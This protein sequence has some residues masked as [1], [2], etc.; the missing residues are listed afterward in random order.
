MAAK[1]VTPVRRGWQ[2]LVPL[3]AATVLLAACGGEEIRTASG[4]GATCDVATEKAWL[5]G[6]MEDRY[7]WSGLAANP[8]PAP[9]AS[10][11]DYFEA[12]RYRP[13]PA[14]TTLYD[15]W[16]YIA[17]KASY[18][19]FFAEGRTLG[20]GLSV[21]GIEL[22]L[23]LKARYVD[24]GS[25]AAQAGLVRGDTIVSLNGRSAAEL[26]AANDFSALSAAAEGQTLEVVVDRGAGAVP[27]TLQATTYDLVPVTQVKVVGLAGGGRAGYLVLKDFIVQAER[28]LADAFDFFAAQGATQ[29][30][31]DLRYNG[32]GRVSTATTLASLIAGVQNN[33]QVFTQLRYNARHSG[34]NVNYLLGGAGRPGF[35]KV[36][37]LTGPRTCSAS[38]LVVNGLAPYVEVVTLG[39]A[40]CGK[41]FGFN[42]VSNCDSVYSAV[43][44]ESVN[45]LGQ[46]GYYQ[47]IAAQC[48]VADDFSRELG[49]PAEKLLAA[50]GD[51]LVSGACAAAPL[52]E[53]QR[54]LS[55]SRRARSQGAEPGERQGMFVD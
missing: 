1:L 4:G 41:P 42:P 25:P 36:V 12:L 15:A 23:P 53:R 18:F 26:V 50:A 48:A 19:Q 5:R 8:D 51:R 14:V 10:V 54:A 3:L 34:D 38:E 32:G 22:Q 6:Y 2:R 40:S 39:G 49:D 20:Y 29:L 9:Y 31:L 46:G 21:N 43:N 44:F 47:G 52:A 24:P 55:V 45:A 35:D 33:G 30:I 27:L 16:S 13:D 28:P 37:V 17:D 11:S 7:F